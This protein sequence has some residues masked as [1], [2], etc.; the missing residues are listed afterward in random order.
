M[1]L[2]L[3][4]E[5]LSDWY[6]GTG[7]GSQGFLDSKTLVDNQGRPQLSSNMISA[8]LSD[9]FNLIRYAVPTEQL[10][11]LDSWN[12][13]LF[14]SEF[15]SGKPCTGAL[16][17]SA[18]IIED[19]S[20]GFDLAD[21]LVTRDQVSIMQNGA[22]RKGSLRRIQ[23][24]RVGVTL[25]S[26][27]SSPN[28]SVEDVKKIIAL[29]AM[30][31]K[32][33]GGKTRR[34]GGE[35]KLSI[36]GFS[37]KKEDALAFLTSIPDAPI[38]RRPDSIDS[39]VTEASKDYQVSI[40]LLED[41]VIQRRT[42][43]NVIE[44]ETYIPGRILRPALAH[45]VERES[46]LRF[47]WENEFV[48][49]SAYATDGDDFYFPAPACFFSEKHESMFYNL[50]KCTKPELVT[51][52]AGRLVSVDGKKVI[53]PPTTKMITQNTIDRKTQRPSANVGGVYVSQ[54]IPSGTKFC[55][56]VKSSLKLVDGKIKLGTRKRLMGSANITIKEVTRVRNT[57]TEKDICLLFAS[58]FCFPPNSIPSVESFIKIVFGEVEFEISKAFI[59][60]V[61]LSGWN[62]AVSLPIV[63]AAGIAAGSV[64]E[65]KFKNGIT[66]GNDIQ[67]GHRTDEGFG[68]ILV[69]PEILK[70]DTLNVNSP[71]KKKLKENPYQ[72]FERVAC[73]VTWEELI[74]GSTSKNQM[75][76]FLLVIRELK[77]HNDSKTR[78]EKIE[79]WY[80]Q[81]TSNPNRR[82]KWKNS[83]YERAKS[84]LKNPSEYLKNKNI[85]TGNLDPID[86][87]EM[88]VNYAVK[89]VLRSEK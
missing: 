78:S 48:V 51:R 54:V 15:N 1:E 7:T 6:S 50:L 26:T 70:C 81:V 12:R 30:S 63:S 87:L 24:A 89:S 82:L 47:N 72:E 2:K 69:N 65:I 39:K 86:A 76:N 44:T 52:L 58:D 13:Y 57:I 34:G 3:K 49:N 21:Q 73:T 9:G 40:E 14:G 18:A 42:L 46:G 59:R 31:V 37:I 68:R 74:G 17:V 29:L 83:C 75:H 5:M 8:L 80:E 88:V 27:L 45:M 38:L 41:V 36:E 53:S 84:L 32:R 20:N 85:D 25:V 56:T 23:Y 43:G 66:I 55:T 11:K 19:V 64:V 4:I 10:D 35:C 60:P 61:R 62:S 67:S 33:I 16:E 71:N 22:A 79:D 28:E 77:K